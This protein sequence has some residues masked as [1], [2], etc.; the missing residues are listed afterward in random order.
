MRFGYAKSR[1]RHP[2]RSPK[3]LSQ[4]M[5]R[6]TLIKFLGQLL[7]TIDEGIGIQR[8]EARPHTESELEYVWGIL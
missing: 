8:G 7:Y 3:K 5:A 6:K 2:Y 4:F 1:E